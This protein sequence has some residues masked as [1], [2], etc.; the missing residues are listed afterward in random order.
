MKAMKRGIQV[1]TPDWVQLVLGDKYAVTV[2]NRKRRVDR[3]TWRY[4]EPDQVS[5]YY[6]TNVAQ[7]PVISAMYPTVVKCDEKLA[8]FG[9]NFVASANFVFVLLFCC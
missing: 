1:V 8:L 6:T 9:M 2:T 7:V 5:D 4:E 3:M